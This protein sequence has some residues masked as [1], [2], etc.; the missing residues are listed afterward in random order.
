M[1]DSLATLAR[2]HNLRAVGKRPPLKTY[3]SSVWRFREFT[4]SM[5]RNKFRV[6]NERTKFGQL[7]VLL[8]PTLNAAIY[9]LIFEIVLGRHAKG[10]NYLGFVVTGVFMFEYFSNCFAQ[11]AKAITSNAALVRSLKFPRASL[12]IA[13]VLKQFYNFVPMT[14]I[15]FVILVLTGQMPTIEWLLMI[16]LTVIYTMF[17]LGIAFLAARLTVSFRDMTNII[18]FI[19]RILFYGGGVLFQLDSI[20]KSS[21]IVERHPWI[22]EAVL[23]SPVTAF[24]ETFRSILLPQAYPNGYWLSCCIWA[25]LFLVV[26][27]LVFWVAEERYGQDV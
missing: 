25:V 16:P 8:R 7:W 10:V 14:L 12:P 17:N 4:I 5:A 18:P 11:G 1:S 20:F 24:L 3:L 2:E 19:N 15:M 9:G 23:N 27:F 26:G 13:E 6:Q 21:K 22:V